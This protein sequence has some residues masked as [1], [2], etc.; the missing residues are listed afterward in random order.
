MISDV[1]AVEHSVIDPATEAIQIVGRFR[2]PEPVEGEPE[3]IV[4]KDVF[5]ISNYNPKLTS[6]P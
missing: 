4:K 6:F 5:H 3:V 1:L 2:K